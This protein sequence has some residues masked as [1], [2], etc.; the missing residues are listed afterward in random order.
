MFRMVIA[1]VRRPRWAP[2]LL[3]LLLIS[4]DRG[5]RWGVDALSAATRPGQAVVGSVASDYA[6][7][8][9]P[10]PRTTPLDGEAVRT[11]V[12]WSDDLSYGLG[13][14]APPGTAALVLVPTIRPE[15]TTSP[16][17]LRGVILLCAELFEQ[18][19]IAIG[20]GRQVPEG[21]H[22]LVEELGDVAEVKLVVLREQPTRALPL[23]EGLLRTSCE[24]PQALV[25]ADG[26]I[27]VPAVWRDE[28]GVVHGS[29]DALA[30]S[31]PDPALS[32]SG[33]VDLLGAVE[34][35]Y[36][37][38]EALRPRIGAE[39]VPMNAV[40]AGE[41]PCAVDAV[42]SQ[43]LGATPAQVP[44]LLLAAEHRVG[45][46]DWEEIKLNGAP[47]PGVPQGAQ[48]F[49]GPAGPQRSQ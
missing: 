35:L 16:A 27:L 23:P 22:R 39:E 40:L 29:L 2:L 11:L 26:V 15:A 6:L 31:M 45:K 37:F 1:E 14:V 36:V 8:D 25:L 32:D 48:P 33:R 34:P 42:V 4:S 13:N 19:S 38:A 12:R 46:V 49:G 21:Y 43:L 5:P 30:G 3:T 10:H 18:P 44:G 20:V 41:D 7:L 28:T 24:L 9:Q 47:V 17:F